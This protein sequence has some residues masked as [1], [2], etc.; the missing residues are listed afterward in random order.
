MQNV[1]RIKKATFYGYHGVRSE[2]Q[3]VGGKF[4]ADVDIY[5]DFSKAA[6]NDDLKETIDYHKVYSFIYKLALEQKYYLIEAL[7]MKITD[8][9][10]KKFDTITKVAVRIRKNNPPLGGVVDCVEV[11]VV[12]DREEFKDN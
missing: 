2:E 5:T 12:K 3:S 10:L 11:E 6:L 4:E 9:L 7:A 1:I 8:E